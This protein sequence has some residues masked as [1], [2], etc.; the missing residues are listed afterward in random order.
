[1]SGPVSLY[2]RDSI[3]SPDLDG[4]EVFKVVHGSVKGGLSSY[5]SSSQAHNRSVLLEGSTVGITDIATILF[6][7][8]VYAIRIKITGGTLSDAVRYVSDS[9]PPN[10]ASDTIQAANLLTV[11][12]LDETLDIPYNSLLQLAVT[13]NEGWSEWILYDEE[14]EGLRRIDFQTSVVDDYTIQVET[15]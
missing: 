7:P 4:K 9:S 8:G 5:F 13:D 1:M 15:A 2:V 6:P 14:S 11:V 12:G 10:D 3:N